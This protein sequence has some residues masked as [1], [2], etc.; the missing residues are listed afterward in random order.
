MAY[1]PFDFFRRNQ[2]VLFAGLTILVMFMFVLSFGQGDFFSRFPQWVAKFQTTGDKMAVIDGGTIKESQLSDVTKERGLANGYMQQANAKALEA[3]RAAAAKAATAASNEDLRKTLNQDVTQITNILTAGRLPAEVWPLLRADVAKMASDLIVQQDATPR[4]EDKE[5]VKAVLKYATAAVAELTRRTT[6]DRGENGVFF[7]NQPNR[8]DRDRLEFLLWK[9]KAD[10]LGIRYT[11]EDVEKLVDGEFPAGSIEEK[12]LKD[13]ATDVA[14]KAGRMREELYDALA[15]EFRVRAAQTAVL[16]LNAVR[17]PAAPPAATARE[18]YEHFLNETTATK[19][20]MITVP[21][22]VYLAEVEKKLASGELKE[23]TDAELTKIFNE[24]STTDPDPSSPRAGIREPR[25]VGVQWVEV[26][27]KEPYYTA[28]AAKRAGEFKKAQTDPAF[29]AL[30][31]AFP[32]PPAAAARYD[33]YLSGQR[34]GTAF[35]QTE[36]ANPGRPTISIVGESRIDVMT[37]VGSGALAQVFREQLRVKGGDNVFGVQSSAQD[38]LADAEFV[39]PE[40]I[41][42]LVG[43]TGT[44]AVTNAPALAPTAAVTEAAFRHTRE[45]RVLAGI[46]GFLLPTQDGTGILANAVGGA[47][48]VNSSTP[49]PLPQAAVQPVLDQRTTDSLRTGIANADLQDFQKE[50]A[51]IMGQKLEGLKP[52]DKAAQDKAEREHR[53]KL[54]EQAAAYVKGWVEARKVKSG[55]TTEP[56]SLYTLADDPGL[57]PLLQKQ[58]DTLLDP[59]T[60]KPRNPLAAAAF[61]AG[62]VNE[63]DLQSSPEGGMSTRMRPVAGVYQPRNYGPEVVG[64]IFP[65]ALERGYAPFNPAGFFGQLSLFGDEPLTA[66]WRT[67]ELDPVRPLSLTSDKAAREKCRNIWKTNKARELARQAIDAAAATIPKGD[68]KQVQVGQQISEVVKQLRKPFAGTA[69]EAK[70]QEFSQEPQ[71]TVAK[72]LVGP[73]IGAGL[74]PS[75]MPFNP[76]HRAILYPSSNFRDE[77]IAKKDEPVGTTFVMADQPQALFQLMVVAGRDPKGDGTFVNHVLYPTS[78]LG[79]SPNEAVLSAAGLAPRLASYSADA[80]RKAAVALLKA[81]FNYKDENTK[82]LDEKRD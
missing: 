65:Q 23:P 38:A 79:A 52:A 43:L 67:A 16:G 77:L 66:V 25:K 21:V 5:R 39:R 14:T 63:L 53:A 17:N 13:M 46:R 72:L 54:T 64:K 62:F 45:Q 57:A 19:Y 3:S 82:K 36:A 50:L 35:R 29:L 75:L 58:K 51:R 27:G 22:E 12:E 74:P 1:N 20:T 76:T 48:A 9:K 80:D 44:G 33:D 41:A 70:I 6:G 61:G 55:T 28:L 68:D 15:D 8:N 59:I 40:L 31:G 4:T 11:H 71:F 32:A 7:A 81:E 56:R 42:A 73:E 34:Q 24:A 37:A 60:E 47:V 26:T 2:K 78:S 10:K 30:L 49:A 69:A 18:R